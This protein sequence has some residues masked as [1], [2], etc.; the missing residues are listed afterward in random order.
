MTFFDRKNGGATVSKIAQDVRRRLFRSHRFRRELAWRLELNGGLITH[1]LDAL[2]GADVIPCD[3]SENAEALAVDG[4]AV[5][6]AIGSQQMHPASTL[7]VSARLTAMTLRCEVGGP[8]ECAPGI[9]DIFP[10]AVSFSF[11]SDLTVLFRNL[12]QAAR[13]ATTKGF[14]GASVSM[15]WKDEQGSVLFGVIDQRGEHKRIYASE[16]LRIPAAIGDGSDTVRS[17]RVGGTVYSPTS[18]LRFGA[19]LDAVAAD[20]AASLD[21]PKTPRAQSGRSYRG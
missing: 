5:L 8:P 4:A 15:L 14:K 12:W 1:S 18:I 3:L 20:T 19:L 17:P 6:M 10:G 2:L 7:R 11:G 16:P 21:R 13:G 9:V